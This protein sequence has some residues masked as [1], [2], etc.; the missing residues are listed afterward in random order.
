MAKMSESNNNEKLSKLV[1]AFEQRVSDL[2]NSRNMKYISSKEVN[3]TQVEF[4]LI[5][6][7]INTNKK[8]Y[9]FFSN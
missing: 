5:C 6:E 4:N 2:N 3:Q 9:K 7:H 8:W 1:C